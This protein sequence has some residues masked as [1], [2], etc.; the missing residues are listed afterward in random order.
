[1]TG[2][3]SQ[4]SDKKKGSSCCGSFDCGAMMKKMTGIS[5]YQWKDSNCSEFM[6]KF[7]KEN[8]PE[9]GKDNKG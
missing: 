2:S 5:G 9:R 4:N 6:E 3:E 8:D 1:M 7:F